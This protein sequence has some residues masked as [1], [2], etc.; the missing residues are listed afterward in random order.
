[1][2]RHVGASYGA[3]TRPPVKAGTFRLY[4]AVKEMHEVENMSDLA[5]DFLRVE[6]KTEPL[7][8]VLLRGRFARDPKVTENRK[9]EFENAQLRISRLAQGAAGGSTVPPTLPYPS[10]FVDTMSGAV[11]W[12]SA[13]EGT[14]L[15]DPSF[16]AA[17]VLQF[18]FKTAPQR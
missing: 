8:A 9:V 6:F 4:R 11:R 18:E 1:M 10:L 15:A 17:D 5:S 16:S 3:A 2:F 13:D 14:T 12:F 7:E